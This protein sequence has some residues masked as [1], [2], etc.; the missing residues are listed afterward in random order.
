MMSMQSITTWQFK[1]SEPFDIARRFAHLEGTALCYSGG[2]KDS[3]QTSYLC[4]FPESKIILPPSQNS[5]LELQNE[6]VIDESNGCA[7]PRWIGYISYEMGCYADPDKI[8]PHF[9]SALPGCIFYKSTLVIRFDHRSKR[10]TLYSANNS[11]TLEGEGNEFKRAVNLELIDTSDTLE[12]YLE[13]IAAVKESILDGEVY[14]VNLSQQFRFVGEANAFDLFEKSALLNPAPFAAY[15]QCGPFALVSASPERFLR[16]RGAH[17]ETRPIKG[18]APRGKSPSEDTLERD[19]LLSSEKERAELLMITDLMRSDLGKVSLAG[20]VHTRALWRCE[21]YTHVFHLLSII[22]SVANSH[23]H[24]V[25]L[26][27]SLFPGGSVT[28]CPKLRAMEL[29]TQLEQRPRG[30]YTGSIGYF[31]ENG[32]FDFNIAIR[33]LVVHSGSVEMQLGG[34]IVIDSDPVREF[35]ETLHKGRSFFNL[36]GVE[37][38]SS[39]L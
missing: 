16:K 3:A 15:L 6:I 11:I 20:T 24:P 26:I 18:T 38:G 33:T 29:I 19:L 35:E 23:L 21:S 9:T 34:G 1:P 7:F 32:D 17:L 31:A 4:L 39:L 25:A 36:L 27:R 2:F 12:S 8:I 14:Q 5:W 10:A 37:Y 13:K 28:G 22:E 30:A